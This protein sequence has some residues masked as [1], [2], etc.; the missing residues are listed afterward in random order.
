MSS[1][2]NN[3]VRKELENLLSPLRESS[4]AEYNILIS[5]I[6]E[7]YDDPKINQL[8]ATSPIIESRLY[9]WII[10]SVNAENS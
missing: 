2:N 5:L 9:Q 3:N 7:V 1:V 6:E 4:Q 10:N 8:E